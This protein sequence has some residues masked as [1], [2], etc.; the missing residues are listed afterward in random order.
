MSALSRFFVHAATVE[1]FLGAGPTGDTYAAP[2]SVKGLL[3]DGVVLVRTS[4]GEQLVQKSIFFGPLTF[5][6]EGVWYVSLDVFVPESQV[7]VNGKV[8]Q[9]SEVHLR[10]GGSIGL[11]DHIEVDLG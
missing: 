1:T 9:V 5:T 10:D 4:A 2:V 3:D 6:H 8:A 7:T 11:P